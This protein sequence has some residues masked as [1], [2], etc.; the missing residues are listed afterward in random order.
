MGATYKAVSFDIDTK[1]AREI[2]GKKYTRIYTVIEDFMTANDFRHKE[3]SQYISK[4]SISYDA[5]D[6]L[7]GSFAADKPAISKTIRDMNMTSISKRDISL[8]HNFSHDG[9]AGKFKNAYLYN[10]DVMKELQAIGKTR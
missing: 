3:G 10:L 8:N 9:E 4:K 1:V 2:F 5:L 7:W 6:E